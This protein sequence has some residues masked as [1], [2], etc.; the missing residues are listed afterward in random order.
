[1]DCIFDEQ[2][3]IAAAR[4][5][6]LDA[7]NQLVVHYQKLAY[8]VAYRILNDADASADA[9]QDAFLRAYRS[10]GQYRGGSF[11]AW[12]LRIVT[13]LCYDQLRARQRQP[14]ASLEALLVTD[15]APGPSFVDQAESPETHAERQELSRLI[16]AGIDSLPPDQRIAL[17]LCDVAGMNYQEIA[18]AT[19][20]SLGTVK[21]RINRA[22][23][24]LRNFLLAQQELLPVQYRLSGNG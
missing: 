16:Q 15:P 3:L 11:K 7:F 24:K 13:N 9:T 8:H 2:A 18:E 12:L 22:R 17:T 14:T 1:M 4:S 10:L 6:D 21:S 5:G 20:S 19:R 23:G